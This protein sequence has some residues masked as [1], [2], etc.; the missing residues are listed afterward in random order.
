MSE[1]ISEKSIKVDQITA[2][3][4][5]KIANREIANV[6]G[7]VDFLSDSENPVT[8]AVLD[9][10]EKRGKLEESNFRDQLTGLYNRKYLTSVIE[11]RSARD[12]CEPLAVLFCD[13]DHFKEKNDTYGHLAGDDV[14]K[15]VSEALLVNTRVQ[16][17]VIRLG[18]EEILVLLDSVGDTE[19]AKERAESIR[20][21]VEETRIRV[22]S[23]NGTEVNFKQTVSIGAS[24]C[25]RGDDLWEK[26]DAADKNMYSAKDNGRNTVVVSK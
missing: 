11:E 9:S 23:D 7:G 20:K 2:E 26:I 1:N 5:A 8:L 16:D 21:A 12:N 10:L 13:L 3:A 24:I 6:P 19:V 14:L 25:D 4:A 22:K 15:V 17:A 18:G